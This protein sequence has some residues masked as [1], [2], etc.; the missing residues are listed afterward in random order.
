MATKKPTK[1]PK[2]PAKKPQKKTPRATQ[3]PWINTRAGRVIIG[4]SITILLL[5]LTAA[6]V[7]YLFT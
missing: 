6:C 1:T 4:I 5:L 3:T 7:S 2:S